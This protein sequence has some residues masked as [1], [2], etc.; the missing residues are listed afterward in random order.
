[1]NTRQ[2]RDQQTMDIYL[3]PGILLLTISLILGLSASGAVETV[4]V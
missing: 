1:M 2:I 3:E 4:R